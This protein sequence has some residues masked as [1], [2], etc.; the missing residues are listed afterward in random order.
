MNPS[1]VEKYLAGELAPVFFGS[2]MNNFGVTRVTGYFLRNFTGTKGR[3]TDLKKIEP[4]ESKMSLDLSLKFTPILTQNTAIVL[5][6]LRIVSGKF[7]RNKF[8]KHVRL[9]KENEVSQSNII[10]GAGQKRD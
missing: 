4:N 6:F 7:E 3:E 9:D 2:A 5:P 8:Y 1:T 10:H